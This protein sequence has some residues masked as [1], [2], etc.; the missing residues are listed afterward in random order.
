MLE[1]G[2]QNLGQSNLKSCSSWCGLPRKMEKGK[3]KP[4]LRAT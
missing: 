3:L 1:L 2:T 4:D